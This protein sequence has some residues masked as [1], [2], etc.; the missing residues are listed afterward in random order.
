M[1]T[2]TF[3]TNVRQSIGKLQ[4]GISHPY[5]AVKKILY[6]NYQEQQLKLRLHTTLCHKRKNE[7]IN[8]HGRGAYKFMNRLINK[9]LSTERWNSLETKNKNISHLLA[10]ENR[11]RQDNDYCVP[12]INLTDHELTNMEKSHLK[13]GLHHSSIRVNMLKPILPQN[14]N[15]WSTTWETPS[16]QMN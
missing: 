1:F 3:D 6:A 15:P 14:L 5:A 7:I 12:I 16:N 10:K 8:N 11:V 13:F 2:K 9:Q 4:T